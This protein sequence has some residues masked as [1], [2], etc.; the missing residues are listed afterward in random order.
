MSEQPPEVAFKVPFRLVPVHDVAAGVRS[1]VSNLDPL[2]E[3]ARSGNSEAIDLISRF[4]VGSE[5]IYTQ[6][7][8]G[9]LMDAGWKRSKLMLRDEWKAEFE[10]SSKRIKGDI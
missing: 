5:K 3:D 9:N 8:F 1:L 6:Y 4:K 10:G 2:I 7:A